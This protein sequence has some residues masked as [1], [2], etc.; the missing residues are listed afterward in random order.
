MAGLG[1]AGGRIWE[2]C[3]PRL[4]MLVAGFG[5]VG[6]QVWWLGLG[7]LIAGFGN[8]GIPVWEYL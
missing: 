8:V 6:G 2:C 7:M 1:N 3:L 5:N 4:G